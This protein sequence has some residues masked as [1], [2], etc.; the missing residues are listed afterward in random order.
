MLARLALLSTPDVIMCT[1]MYIT[2]CVHSN[3]RVG[4]ERLSTYLVYQAAQ[5]SVNSCEFISAMALFA[6]VNPAGQK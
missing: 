6:A 3:G 5:L 4:E 2:T 1:Y